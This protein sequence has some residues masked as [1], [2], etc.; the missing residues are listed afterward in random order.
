MV[1]IF[2]IVMMWIL[3]L[4]IGEP[5]ITST[6]ILLGASVLFITIGFQKF[7]N[8]GIWI[9]LINVGSILFFYKQFF[10][11]LANV[12][13]SLA[14]A[15]SNKNRVSL[16]TMTVNDSIS[17]IGL[18]L[19]ILS[20]GVVLLFLI[21]WMY[22]KQLYLGFLT[23]FLLCWT[24]QV[25]TGLYSSPVLNT[26][27][28]LATL[29]IMI[30]SK[31]RTNQKLPFSLI[32]SGILAMLM[33]IWFSQETYKQPLV[34]EN[35]QERTVH[36]MMDFRFKRNT[37]DYLTEGNLWDVKTRNDSDEIA[38]NIALEQPTSMYLKGFVG[39]T[40]L[41][42]E[43]SP[44]HKEIYATE[45]NRL[46][47][48]E[49]NNF[50]AAL[51]L[52]TPM[53][54]DSTNVKI[55]IVNASKKYA[56]LPYELASFSSKNFQTNDFSTYTANSFFGTEQLSFEIMPTIEKSFPII[57]ETI[58]DNAQEQ[59]I[60]S[61]LINESFYNE[62]VY[63]Y[64]TLLDEDTKLLLSQHVENI[65]VQTERLEYKQAIDYVQKFLENNLTY[66]ENIE[67]LTSDK[68]YL[69]YL[70]EQNNAGYAPHYAT[71][72]TLLFRFLQIPA[73]YVEGY[74]ISSQDVKGMEGFSEVSITG[75]NAHS[76]TEIYIDA[77]GWVPIETTPPY[78]ELMPQIMA[79]KYSEEMQ[80]VKPQFNSIENQTIDDTPQYV[81]EDE[82][83]HLTESTL[84]DVKVWWEIIFI[85]ILLALI[86]LIVRTRRFKLKGEQAILAMYD[87]M[88]QLLAYKKIIYEG[89][90]SRHII[91]LIESEI[92]TSG[93]ELYESAVV[94][95]QQILYSPEPLTEHQQREMK[96]IVQDF[97][98]EI[99]KSNKPL[100]RLAFYV[101]YAMKL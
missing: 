22:L 77:I 2:Y 28:A 79:P 30:N 67:P 3:F 40:Y 17:D 78:L 54:M 33:L 37:I 16:P 7:K 35:V 5:I 9:G 47:A 96:T 21:E 45:Y 39:E 26:V 70:L 57:A 23:L 49:K 74:I 100:S 48:L 80:K 4:W 62:Y 51:Q 68:D 88:H 65:D 93:A 89:G 10:N 11:E 92:S 46:H 98:R 76:W 19:V 69:Q 42:G 63:K 94:I 43:W 15:L 64:E 81:R 95:V 29:V 1:V 38:L 61:Y 14:L 12:Y 13:N 18:C 72:A 32:F 53:N 50:T 87:D 66:N 99:A 83:E 55:Q 82:I 86:L 8:L 60:S 20:V 59:S 101:R 97:K 6:I 58:Y 91:P 84:K 56:Y 41:D 44:L 25:I 85:L 27:L 90:S 52:S 73:R 31:S 71:V 36:A 24:V 75:K 34:F